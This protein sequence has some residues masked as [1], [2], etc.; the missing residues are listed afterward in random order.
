MGLGRGGLRVQL[1]H[2]AQC[3]RAELV[4][5]LASAG[6]AVSAATN[7]HEAATEAARAALRALS[8]HPAL[9]GRIV[10]FFTNR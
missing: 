9:N 10:S 1:F 3:G 4:K 5:L 8:A 7:E 2:A 6:A